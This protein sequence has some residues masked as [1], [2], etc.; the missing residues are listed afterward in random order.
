MKNKKHTYTSTT[1]A[2]VLS[3]LALGCTTSVR[4]CVECKG[5]SRT[6][7]LDVQVVDASGMPLRGAEVRIEAPVY[8]VSEHLPCDPAGETIQAG[9]VEPDG[10]YRATFQL[11]ARFDTFDLVVDKDGY[12][13]EYTFES[14]RMRWQDEAPSMRVHHLDTGWI[15]GAIVLEGEAE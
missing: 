5:A 8:P 6:V 10:T 1:L 4:H 15:A 12:Q 9:R 2:L 7:E 3:L 13:G 14:L 11:P